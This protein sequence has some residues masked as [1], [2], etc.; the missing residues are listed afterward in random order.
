[1]CLD[2]VHHLSHCYIRGDWTKEL[3]PLGKIYILKFLQKEGYWQIFFNRGSD[4]VLFTLSLRQLLFL[5]IAH[6][7]HCKFYGW[8]RKL[9]NSVDKGKRLDS[10]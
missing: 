4:K 9:H 6:Q 8:L 1:M 10:I 3:E 5:W 2:I 7:S